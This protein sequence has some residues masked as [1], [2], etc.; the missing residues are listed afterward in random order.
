MKTCNTNVHK[1]EP[2][3][4]AGLQHQCCTDE[5]RPASRTRSM[6][7]PNCQNCAHLTSATLRRPNRSRETATC[8]CTSARGLTPADGPRNPRS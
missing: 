3:P 1:D 6:R 8:Q 7:K 4:N 2:R 5:L